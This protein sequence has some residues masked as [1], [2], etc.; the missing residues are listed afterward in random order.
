MLYQTIA[1]AL[2]RLSGARVDFFNIGGLA[3]QRTHDSLWGLWTHYS[4]REYFIRGGMLV[5]TAA[6]GAL[7]A[8]SC[9]EEDC[10]PVLRGIAGAGIGFFVT[11]ALVVI[12]TIQRRNNIIANI[13]Y[14]TETLNQ[15]L[16]TL[17]ETPSAL[18]NASFKLYIVNIR[19]TLQT[20]H[21]DYDQR[22][23]EKKGDA[24]KNLVIKKQALVKLVTQL[25]DDFKQLETAQDPKE[26]IRML[27]DINGRW[28][29]DTTR[30]VI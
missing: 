21:S 16:A 9:E 15:T 29:A 7:G 6:L 14:L 20:I 1:A 13:A 18:Q 10:S 24:I 19:E 2:T 17:E 26:V 12:P 4:W 22:P 23:L 30:K 11:H 28:I 8:T 5:A 25:D 27:D 3:Q